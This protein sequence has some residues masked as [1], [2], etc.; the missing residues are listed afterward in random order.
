[1]EKYL[2]PR[3]RK[4]SASSC[5]Q[6][7]DLEEPASKIIALQSESSQADSS[8]STCTTSSSS[9]K[10]RSYKGKL[11]YDPKWK[12]L[13]PWMEY[14]SFLK[15]MVCSV[16]TSFGKVPVQAKG[17]WVTR[18]VCNW[19]KATSL[20]AKHGKADWHKAALE[21]QKLSL[22]ADK[23]GGV[24]EQIISASEEDKLHNRDFIKKLIR[25]LYFL[26]K[27][28]IP[29]TT[30]FEGLITLQIEN[31]DIK[32]RNHRDNSPRNAT[33]ES[34]ATVLDLLSSIS[35]VLERALLSSS[36]V[37]FSLMA[38]ESTDVSSKEELSICA[39]WEQGGKTVEHFLGIMTAKET[40]AQA[41]ST[42]L[43]DFLESKSINMTK[44]R[45]IGF[46][47]ANTMSGKRSGV[48]K[49]LRLHS[50][51]AV[52][53]HC[54]CH[55]LQ[56]A[57]LNA[58]DQHRDVKRVVGTLLTIWK[59]FY[60]SPKK[61]E[62]LL[63]I[64]AVLNAPELKMVKPSDTRWL[65]RERAVRAVRRSLPALVTTFEEI[66]SKTGDAE[67]H[68]LA[69]LLT[70]YNTVACIYMLSDVLHIVAKLQ[71]SLQGKEVDLASVPGMVESTLNRLKELK[72]DTNTTTWFK[73]HSAVFTDNMQ[74]GDR[75]INITDTM[76]TQF[77]Q[78]VY[79][80]YIESVINNIQS[81]IEKTD[82]IS[83]M[84]VFDPKHLP[85][86]SELS[87]YGTEK[88]KI[89]SAWY[90]S[91]QDVQFDGQKGSSEPDIDPEDT[92]SEWKLFRQLMHLHHKK[93][94]LQQVLSALLTNTSLASTFPNLAKLAAILIVLP[95][96][97][98]TVERTFSSMKLI[99]TRLRNRMGESTL[100]HTM[101]ICIEGPDRLS[102]E[103][104][105]E[106]I[107]HYKHSKQRRIML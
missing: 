45:G 23:H 51:S 59:A 76:K 57:T 69:T 47:G 78:K 60:Y 50:P 37:Y 106:V 90:G 36:S 13:Y 39:R 63:E 28:H 61:A 49:R 62:K 88:I 102:N 71:G 46:D 8:S 100:E 2:K 105:E 10:M 52:Y 92:E 34:Y 1:M 33:Y 77:V 6:D 5:D 82:L 104:L 95:V 14:D 75:N 87:D 66:Y 43:C 86:E 56:L 84:A 80:P 40:T 83:S 18:P 30:T 42:Y 9:C 12:R 53:V 99:K 72:E 107:D 48:Q 27:Q 24:V 64:Q 94:S 103:T 93:S 79:R 3:K 19:V 101:R 85:N 97:T 32:L 54:R 58:A 74:L 22:L 16:C 55:Q 68:G 91:V 44:M 21:K 17:A 41:I 26:V 65:S 67:A 20:L 98:A 11:Y 73:E 96:T 4:D 25:S 29:H 70:K 89:L 38:D 81:R 15:G 35:K 31:D 7:S